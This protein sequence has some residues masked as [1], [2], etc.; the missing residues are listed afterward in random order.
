MI[1][2]RYL[3][4]NEHCSD[5]LVEQADG[6]IGQTGVEVERDGGQSRMAALTFVFSDMLHRGAAGVA[7]ELSKTSL[8]HAMSV[9]RI[10]PDRPDM[11]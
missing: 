11:F 9:S 2:L 7:D 3:G 1:R 4:S 5:E 6:L 8:M 10:K